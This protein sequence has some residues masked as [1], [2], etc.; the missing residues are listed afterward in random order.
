MSDQQQPPYPPQ[1]GQPGPQQPPP[2]P[3]Y[4]QQPYPS[5]PY[6]YAAQPPLPPG[7]PG[8]GNQLGYPASGAVGQVRSTGLCIL[9]YVVT[10]GIY[11]LVYYFK[12]HQ[13]MRDH[14]GRGIGG[15]VA[16]VLAF[17]VGIVMPFITSSEVGD[18]YQ[19]RG[20]TRPVSGATGLWA[21]PG[22]FIL[23]GPFIWFIQTNGALNNYWRSLGA[24]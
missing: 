16:L 19:R 23:V 8:Y 4:P 14:A 12:V 5:Q 20:Q 18:L 11:G 15:G 7:M 21:F 10:L 24:R 2:G 22:V 13:E 1:P 6:P 9:L 17:F 3:P